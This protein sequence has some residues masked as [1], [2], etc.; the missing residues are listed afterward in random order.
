LCTSCRGGQRQIVSVTP[1]VVTSLATFSETEGDAWREVELDRRTYGEL[2][3]VL[4]HY[5]THLLGHELRMHR[6]LGNLAN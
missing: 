1:G 6:Y 2:R 4:N 5:W 3:A